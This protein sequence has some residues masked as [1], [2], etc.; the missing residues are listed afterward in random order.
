MLTR[1][2]THSDNFALTK[3]VLIAVRRLFCR[4]L[5]LS[6]TCGDSS[7]KGRAQKGYYYYKYER[8]FCQAEKGRQRDFERNFCPENYA[9]S[10]TGLDN[11]HIMGYK[12]RERSAQGDS[13]PAKGEAGRLP[14]SAQREEAK[15]KQKETAIMDTFEKI[16]A[17]LAEQLDIDPAKITMDS[18]I[19]G[20]FEADSLDIVD[21]VMTLE[22]EFG[23][24]VPDDA[25]ENL[26]TVGDVVKF[27]DSHKG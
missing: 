5:A 12:E 19:M 16:R 4:G 18:D 25:I 2:R 17:L 7:P 22:D 3:G 6:V 20:D 8:P 13:L 23:I 14:R 26:R 15:L 10:K 1:K 11:K 21:M 27:V 9:G 24:E